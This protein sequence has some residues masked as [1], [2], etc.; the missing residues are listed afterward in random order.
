M[1]PGASYCPFVRLALAR[2]QP[3]SV[4][5]AE[6]SRIVLCDFAQ[7]LPDRTLNV[8]ASADGKA[9]QIDVEGFAHH[10]LDKPDEWYR[11][12]RNGIQVT[13]G[14]KDPGNPD[15]DVGWL[16][17]PSNTT[18][19]IHGGDVPL[20][21]STGIPTPWTGTGTMPEPIGSGKYRLFVTE[22]LGGNIGSPVYAD[23]IDM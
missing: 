13:V 22:Y 1:D 14:M 21:S 11:G 7:L 15:P 6:L 2:Y 10:G 9:L 19:R 12:G 16:A 18:A 20:P 4:T 8:S 3:N 17:L 5:G 23:T